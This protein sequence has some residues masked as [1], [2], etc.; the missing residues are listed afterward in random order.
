MITVFTPIIINLT[1]EKA[2]K[3]GPGRIRTC[4]QAISGSNPVRLHFYNLLD[5]NCKTN[6]VRKWWFGYQK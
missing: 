4:D 3:G 6:G 1:L 5:D 2:S